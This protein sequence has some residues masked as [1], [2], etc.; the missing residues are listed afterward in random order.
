L[1]ALEPF[2]KIHAVQ[3]GQIDIQHCHIRFGR[4]AKLDGFMSI[5]AS[6]DAL[7]A[8]CGGKQ[9]SQHLS[10]DGLV[11]YDNKTFHGWLMGWCA[12]VT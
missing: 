10:D 9:F 1:G 6:A 3:T 4:G 2:Q 7:E 5:S 11:F 8:L 12:G